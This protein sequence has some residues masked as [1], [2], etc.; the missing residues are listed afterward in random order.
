MVDPF[1]LNKDLPIYVLTAIAEF[2]HE[3]NRSYCKMVGDTPQ[4]PWDELPQE[5]K[6]SVITA[7]RYVQE[8]PNVTPKEMHEKWMDDKKK[9]GWKF[10]D[11]KDIENKKHPCMR[12]FEELPIWQK[13]K[14]D[15]FIHSARTA[16]YSYLGIHNEESYQRNR[17]FNR[18]A[19][20]NIA[21]IRKKLKDKF[22]FFTTQ[23]RA[24]IKHKDFEELVMLM[25]EYI[26]RISQGI[27]HE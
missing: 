19:E 16:I 27:E 9:N 22:N 25:A 18:N 17:A 23:L 6:A 24:S 14:D 1:P 21:E 5:L 4:V 20:E 7:I 2:C 12:P 11:D 8:S 15:L 13:H 26:V 3:V 10:G